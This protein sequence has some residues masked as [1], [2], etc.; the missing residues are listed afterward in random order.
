VC[1]CHRVKTFL[2]VL[3]L[4][5]GNRPVLGSDPQAT[6]KHRAGPELVKIRPGTTIDNGPPR[7]WS[8]LVVKS[9]PRLASGDLQSLPRSAFRTATLFRTVI[10]AD[11]GRSADHPETFSLDRV[12]I[13]LCMPDQNGRDVV[14]S[15]GRLEESGVS[16]GF[17]EKTVLKAA[18]AELVRGRLIRATS[19]FALYR[20]PTLM[21]GE[22]GHRK[23]VV[24][25]A[26]LVGPKTGALRTFV[27]VQDARGGL[28]STVPEVVELKPNLVFDCPINVE[29]GRLLGT[30]PVTWSF[31]MESLPPGQR[32]NIALDSSSFLS[33]SG[34]GAVD[35]VMIERELRQALTGKPV[36][37]GS[38]LT[39][40]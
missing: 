23:V 14:V 3:V 35:S 27:W 26:F 36:S 30:V 28:L 40:P 20:A 15:S 17:V 9:L 12:G 33:L 1:D 10:L 24:T 11:V 32:R 31:A 7:S 6:E 34:T 16:L 38:A 5:A 29:A 2:L 25:Y 8:H 18:E 4:V 37:A 19:T 39:G 13:G 22:Q 21:Q